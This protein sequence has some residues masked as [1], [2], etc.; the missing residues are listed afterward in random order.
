MPKNVNETFDD[1]VYIKEDN[2]VP[3]H[4]Y[5]SNGIYFV[6]GTKVENVLEGVYADNL[7]SLR[8]FQRFLENEGIMDELRELGLEDSDTV[9][10]CGFEFDYYK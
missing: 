8:Y 1:T 3:V 4:V 2:E 9:D 7:D 10:V 5:K 6:E